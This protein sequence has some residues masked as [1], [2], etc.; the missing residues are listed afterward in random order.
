MENENCSNIFKY[1]IFTLKQCT[2]LEC[3]QTNPVNLI[4]R[5]FTVCN[6]LFYLFGMSMYP[7]LDTQ[8][9]SSK[10]DKGT[11]RKKKKNVSNLN[12]TVNRK[13]IFRTLDSFIAYSES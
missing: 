2:C 6:S 13:T 7:T 9:L 10:G 8:E 1:P 4:N 3:H 5:G 11:S 12:R